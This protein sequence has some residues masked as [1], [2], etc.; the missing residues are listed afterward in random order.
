[1]FVIKHS[2]HS[3][4]LWTAVPICCVFKVSAGTFPY[5]WSWLNLHC[6]IH[7]NRGDYLPCTVTL[8][9]TAEPPNS[10]LAFYCH[11]IIISL[12]ASESCI[13]TKCTVS[14]ERKR[15]GEP[16]NDRIRVFGAEGVHLRSG[17][18]Y[19]CVSRDDRYVIYAPYRLFTDIIFNFQDN[20][21]LKMKWIGLIS[22]NKVL[23]WLMHIS[24]TS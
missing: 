3:I 18:A 11:W 5:K 4:L 13:H 16:E 19:E 20:I 24:R 2:Q 14:R 7:L 1:M 9:M 23:Y 15:Q 6:T 8:Q 22:D 21:M 10:K 12:P 17:S